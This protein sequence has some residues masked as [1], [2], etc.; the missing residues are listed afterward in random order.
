[1]LEILAELGMQQ[2]RAL[3]A[4]HAQNREMIEGAAEQGHGIRRLG[5]RAVGERGDMLLRNLTEERLN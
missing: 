3:R 4:G 5:L 1:M 2:I